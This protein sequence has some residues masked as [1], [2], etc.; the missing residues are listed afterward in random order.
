MTYC[1]S[2]SFFSLRRFGL[3]DCGEVVATGSGKCKL[4][5]LRVERAGWITS[6][7]WSEKT[8]RD[9]VRSLRRNGVTGALMATTGLL[10]DCCGDWLFD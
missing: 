6:V 1:Q 9:L 2:T 5:R 7:P 4:T 8:I 10:N 3:M